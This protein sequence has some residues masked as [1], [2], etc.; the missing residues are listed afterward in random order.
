[1]FSWDSTLTSEG[2]YNVSFTATDNGDG[3]RVNKSS[4]IVVP[5]I[6]LPT[7]KLT[8]IAA[9]DNQTIQCGDI[10][11]IPVVATDANGDPLVLTGTGTTGYTLIYTIQ[12]VTY[13]PTR[14]QF[15]V[16]SS[17]IPI[18]TGA[19]LNQ[20]TGKFAWKPNYAQAGEYTFKFAVLDAYGGI[21][22]KEVG[23]LIDNV[24]RQ[25]TLNVSNHTIQPV[26]V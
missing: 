10:I 1:M 2:T 23:V 20:Y 17:P 4:T 13:T 25:P 9:I 14:S 5:I 3:T 21:D 24:N 11:D 7:D 8:V 6:V 15:P 19:Y 26:V 18:P 16:P 22:T 12:G